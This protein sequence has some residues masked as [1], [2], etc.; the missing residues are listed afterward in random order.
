[1]P[2]IKHNIE[3]AQ[4]LSFRHLLESSDVSKNDLTHILAL[5]AQYHQQAKN[6]MRG[7][8]DCQGYILA[9]LFFE[10]STRTRFS[11]ESAMLR[12]GG[13][14]LTLEQGMSSS[15]KKG[16]S[17]H[18][19]GRIVSGYAD[20]IVM[21]HANA[22]SPHALAKGAIVPVI[23]GGDG[24]NQ[25]P[26]QSLAD[27]YTIQ[28]EKGRLDNLTI[29]I[30][31]D[32]KYSRTVHSLT[33]LMSLYPNNK[34]V[35]ISHPSLR[36]AADKRKELEKNGCTVKETDKLTDVIGDLDVLYVTRV[37]EERF[38]YPEEYAEVKDAFRISREGLAKAKPT[39]TVMHPLPRVNEIDA[40]VDALPQARYFE[41][42][43]RAVFVRMAL[44]SLIK[45]S[46]AIA[47]V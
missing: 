10:P 35:L 18:D 32:L 39:L 13:Q 34:F 22:G 8:T 44:L 21:R 24:P 5:A 28:L 6:G 26:T 42:A 41:Q 33:E 12:L 15:L 29:G 9:T 43:S 16:E 40:D 37:Q 3:N 1:M 19:T 17:M 27:L 47:G 7:W 38:A 4:K 31:G 23:N 46:G 25:H 14:V 30:A 20:M 11:F 2:N 45:G 36:L